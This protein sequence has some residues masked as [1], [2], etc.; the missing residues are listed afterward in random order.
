[1]DNAT[2]INNVQGLNS[3]KDQED[4]YNLQGYKIPSSQLSTL[5]SQ[6]SNGIYIHGG[7]KT[8][9]STTIISQYY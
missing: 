4:I 6:L 1:V 5:N 8:V 7:K 3:S 2:G 9:K